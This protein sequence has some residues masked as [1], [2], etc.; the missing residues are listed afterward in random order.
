MLA[1]PP[2]NESVLQKCA[3]TVSLD[4]RL[5]MEQWT[6]DG[7]CAKPGRHS[8]D[9]ILRPHALEERVYRMRCV[10]GWSMVIP[11][12]GFPLGD[13]LRRFEPN[14]NAQFVQFTTVLRP[15]EM[16]GQRQRFP[17]ILP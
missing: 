7:D 10:E 4:G 16:P 9:D 14:G 3:P 11:W 5:V 2:A 12:I 1:E 15:K 8:L 13:L 17:S 6:R